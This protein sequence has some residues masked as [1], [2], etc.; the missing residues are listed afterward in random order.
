VVSNRL[1]ALPVE[2]THELEPMMLWLAAAAF[3][4]PFSLA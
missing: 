4:T 3:S 2:G 1:F